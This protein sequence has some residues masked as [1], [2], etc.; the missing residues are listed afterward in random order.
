M[1]F[2]EDFAQAAR[3]EQGI[4]ALAP[5]VEITGDDHWCVT[6]QFFQAT[7]Q[8]LELFRAVAFT[9]A[10]VNTNGMHLRAFAG[11]AQHAMQDAAILVAADRYVEIVMAHDL[12]FRQQRITV[13]ARR[14]D[15]VAPIGELRPEA[16]AR[17]SYCG[18]AGQLS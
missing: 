13:I 15:R 2:G 1:V 3:L 8:Q 16:V 14:V 12:E 11:Q 5:V 18:I 6:G 17:N 4:G 9:Q 7:G 10:Q